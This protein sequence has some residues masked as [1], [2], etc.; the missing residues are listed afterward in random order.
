MIEESKKILKTIAIGFSLLG[1]LAVLPTGSALAQGAAAAEVVTVTAKVIAV[2][3]ENRMV[4]LMGEEGDEFVI[5]AG[6]EVTNFD[7]IEV[8]DTVNAGYMESIEIFLG[9]PGAAPAVEE[10]QVVERAAEGEKPAG[11]VAR[12]MQV[13]A[14]VKAIDKK[15]RVLTLALEDGR[16]I[17]RAVDPSIEAFDK[18]KVGDTINVRL[19]RV[20][21]VD[22]ERM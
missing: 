15:N 22:V 19:T 10:A 1:A 13:S 18:L 11:I 5:E 20:L 21:A 14:S 8:G 3:K 4:T 17:E 7:Q 12:A 2:D 6:D 16:E 9:E